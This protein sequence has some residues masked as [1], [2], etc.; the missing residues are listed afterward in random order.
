MKADVKSFLAKV[1]EI[2]AECPGYEQGHSGDDHLC[3]CI[4]L[5]IGALKRCGV[6]WSGI[7]GSNYAAR[8]EMLDLKPIT[9]SADL[10][11]GEVVYKI[12][13]PGAEKYRL[14]DKY[15]KG[16]SAYNGDLLDYYHVGVV[17]SSSPLRI[18]HMTTPQPKMDTSIGKWAYYGWLKKISSGGG[19]DKMR[20]SYRARVI[21]GALNLRQQMDTKSAR[22]AQIPDGATVQVTEEY[23]E[24]CLV[25]YEGQTGYVLSKFLAEIQ[26]DPD[27]VTETITVNKKQLEA[28][29]DKIGDMLGL[30][31]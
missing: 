23:P 8:S 3:D 27:G 16:G 6:R 18:R 25:E 10:T 4:G 24:W 1:E 15:Q 2:A 29:Y 20:V 28:I 19:D 5:I 7:H 31:G 9:K 14:P 26:K 30:R 11:P 21:G 12:R 13:S 17:V 22:I